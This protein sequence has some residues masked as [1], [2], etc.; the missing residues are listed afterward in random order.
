MYTWY[1]RLNALATFASTILVVMLAANFLTAQLDVIDPDV[2]VSISNVQLFRKAYEDYR[3]PKEISHFDI[4]P[5]YLKIKGDLRPL[6]NWNVKHIFLYIS[7]TYKTS[8]NRYNSV[9]IWDH[10]LK[11]ADEANLDFSHEGE[12]PLREQQEDL[13]GVPIELRLNW[14]VVPIA[15]LLTD[16]S[17]PLFNFTLPAEYE[18]F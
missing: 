7:A 3:R 10:I 6:F 13:R 17:K 15:G 18:N 14:E 16:Y 5:I 12:Y 9:T 8:A 11:T 1:Y 2:S 4:A